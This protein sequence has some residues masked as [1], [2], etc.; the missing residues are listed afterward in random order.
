MSER[1]RMMTTR[2]V[3]TRFFAV[4][5]LVLLY[6]A[7]SAQPTLRAVLEGSPSAP[8]TANTQFTVLVTFEGNPTTY[9]LLNS[10]FKVTYDSRRVEL[11]GAAHVAGGFLWNQGAEPDVLPAIGQPGA[12][13]PA[14]RSRTVSVVDFAG[15]NTKLF[16]PDPLINGDVVRLTFQT[17][18]WPSAPY[19][20]A[21][22]QVDPQHAGSEAESPINFQDVETYLPIQYN[23][24]VAFD[25]T[26]VQGLG[27]LDTDL[28][29]IPD[30]AEVSRP[31]NLT[32]TSKFIRDSDGDGLTDGEENT[33]GTNPRKY[34][35]DAD[36]LSDFLEVALG[37]N[38][39]VAN[40]VVDAD[41]DGYP[42]SVMDDAG[43]PIDL[44]LPFGAG[45]LGGADPNDADVDFDK[46]GYADGYELIV[47]ANGA[48]ASNAAQKPSLGDINANGTVDIG[49]VLLSLQFFEKD[50]AFYLPT[51]KNNQGFDVNR[52]GTP[53]ISD[54]LKLLNRFD[55]GAKFV[56]PSPVV[57]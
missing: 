50:S 45:G 42:A 54:V 2:P 56:F 37:T 4:A 53:D 47:F 21:L 35:T 46:D 9:S 55:Q 5:A 51:V 31:T 10:I 43:Q 6:G 57:P 24:P 49:D 11:V 20:I 32:Q 1:K 25:N 29:L 44:S 27:A 52:N 34:D 19:G 13:T 17:T 8:A 12:G 22:S 14:A 23:G 7:V 26:S 40:V 18:K 36:G 15:S 3:L 33:Y 28:D 30:F 48:A 16:T 39:L 38:P 41:K